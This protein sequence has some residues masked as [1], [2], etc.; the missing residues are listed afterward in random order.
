MKAV[1]L[2]DLH[3]AHRR[4]DL[5]RHG[6]LEFSLVDPLEV[7]IDGVRYRAPAG[8]RTDGASTPRVF[9]N[10]VPRV[11]RHLYGAIIHDAA[12]RGVLEA[13]PGLLEFD[14]D[15][16]KPSVWRT[17]R[18]TRAWADQAFLAVMEAAQTGWMTRHMAYWAVRLCGRW[19]YKGSKA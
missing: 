6:S 19:S 13:G 16:N 5:S 17:A 12:Y 10:L 7:E 11:G 9:R 14:F 4:E 15:G 2:S 18:V 8:A 3:S 1:I